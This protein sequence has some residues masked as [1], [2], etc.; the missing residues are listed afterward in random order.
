MEVVVIGQRQLEDVGSIRISGIPVPH[1]SDTPQTFVN[2]HVSLL[3]TG[4]LVMENKR[5]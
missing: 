2:P 1:A 3:F 5:H 4:L